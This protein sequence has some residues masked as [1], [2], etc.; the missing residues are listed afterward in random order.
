MGIGTIIIIAVLAAGLG[1]MAGLLFGGPGKNRIAEAERRA[2]ADAETLLNA[3]KESSAKL[4][5]AEKEAGARAL[6]LVKEEAARQLAEAKES[7]AR[8]LAETKEDAARQLAETKE[9]AAKQLAESKEEAEKRHKDALAQQQRNFDE[10]I[11]KVQAQLRTATNEMLKERQ[12]EFAE[13][14][15]KDLGQIVNPLKETID[16]MKEEMGKATEQQGRMSVEMKANMENMLRHSDEARKSADELARAFKHGSKVQGDWGETVLKELL[17]SQGLQEGI[18]YDIQAVIRDSAGNAVH[19]EAG[20][21]LRP[22][23]ILHLD[24]NRE[25]IIDSKVSLK[26]FM[27][28]A[29]AET[30]E[31][32]QRALKEHVASVRKHVEE[33][34]RKDYSSYICPPKVK[35]D[36]VIM[37]VPHTG[38]LWTALNAEPALW[39]SAMEKGVF[40]TDEQNLYAA[41]RIISMTWTQI[42]QA[43]NHEKIFALATEMMDRV[44][45]FIKKYETVG[46]ALQSAQKAYEEGERKL[47]P[48]GQSILQTCAK[49]E[50]LGARQS[51]TNPLPQL[52][53]DIPEIES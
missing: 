50:K 2:R 33:L 24:K 45:Q 34:A 37:F 36:Y 42:R 8:Q 51:K 1:L 40:I 44:G 41:L 3:E 6:T 29:N 46:K 52:S 5:E 15:N 21:T 14:S 18:H 20:S 25:V 27:D 48:G 49:L 11:A 38:A 32:R 28:Y 35:M 13:S 16:K 9:N 4:I 39:R 12:K 23:V 26:A 30:E 10:T 17:D 19:P 7:S 43:E 47:Q 31:D 53:D 22:D